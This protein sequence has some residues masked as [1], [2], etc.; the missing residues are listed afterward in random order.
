[1]IYPRYCKILYNKFG[2]LQQKA[3]TISWML[4]NTVQYILYIMD[5][6]KYCIVYP[7]Y[8][9]LYCFKIDPEYSS[10]NVLRV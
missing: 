1:M 5:I 6:A 9:N 8:Y 3:Y 2:L 4:Q 10:E 7:G